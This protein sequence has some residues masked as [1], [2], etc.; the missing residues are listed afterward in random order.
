M[1]FCRGVRHVTVVLRIR[2]STAVFETHHCTLDQSL[3]AYAQVLVA[4]MT[5][6]W[7]SRGWRT[8]LFEQSGRLARYIM[9][10]NLR[11]SCVFR[12]HWEDQAEY[13]QDSEDVRADW[14]ATCYT[15]DS[16]LP[17]EN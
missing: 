4:T 9:I 2:Y 6:R 13:W 12:N 7:R 3:V 8:S 16:S 17:P 5:S 10:G 11:S 14:R 15:T 1:I